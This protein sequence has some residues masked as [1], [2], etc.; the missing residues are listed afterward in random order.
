MLRVVADR[1]VFVVGASRW[2]RGT[3]GVAARWTRARSRVGCAEGRPVVVRRGDGKGIRQGRVHSARRRHART[4][5]Q[6]AEPRAGSHPVRRD[7]DL[8][9]SPPFPAPTQA[10]LEKRA[11][12]SAR[13][14]AQGRSRRARPCPCPSVRAPRRRRTARVRHQATPTP[15]TK[16]VWRRRACVISSHMHEHARARARA[17]EPSLFWFKRVL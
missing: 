16:H 1:G 5:P 8:G 12:A 17:P 14:T 2:G 10:H 9:P 11:R 4:R 6:K 15:V 7:R 3:S 13:A